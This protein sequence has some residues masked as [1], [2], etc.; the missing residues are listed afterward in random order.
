MFCPQSSGQTLLT[1]C[2][3]LVSVSVSLSMVHVRRVLQMWMCVLP[4]CT[5]VDLTAPVIHQVNTVVS[6][7][8]CILEFLTG[9][10]T[11]KCQCEEGYL[12]PSCVEM[13][14]EDR[15]SVAQQDWVLSDLIDSVDWPALVEHREFV[16]FPGLD[17]PGG[18]YLF[19]AEGKDV[20][21]A[22]RR[23][24]H[25]VAYNTNGIL[26]HSLRPPQQWVQWTESTDHGLYVLDIDYCLMGLEQCPA[27][28]SC[29]RQAPGNFSCQCNPPYQRSTGGHC[30][31]PSTQEVRYVC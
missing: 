30:Q 29:V 18:D 14:R 26:K 11:Y 27:H 12:P 28:S 19:V 15:P 1:T 8:V 5:D 20:E 16:F 24:P 2:T 9:P 21:E 7:V 31:P 13:Y 22:C 10:G 6:R 25:C 23:T 17:S 3:W 4:T